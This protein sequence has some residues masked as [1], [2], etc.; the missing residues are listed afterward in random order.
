MNSLLRITTFLFVAGSLAATASAHPGHGEP[1]PG[2][3][4]TEPVHLLTFATFLFGVVLL[5]RLSWGW[6]MPV[7]RDR[8][9]A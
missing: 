9:N 6:L 7:S 3:H 5:G 2:H 1:G 4:L 8:T